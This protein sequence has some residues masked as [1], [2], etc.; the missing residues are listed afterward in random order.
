MTSKDIAI[1]PLLFRDIEEVV[2]IYAEV[3]NNIYIA[4]G[5]VAEGLATPT[6]FSIKA[7]KLFHQEM[8]RSIKNKV[9]K[10]Y[11]ARY[12]DA[13]VGFIS[14]E[15]KEAPAGHR[16]CWIRDLG[17]KKHFRRMGIAKQFMRE[18][19]AFGKRHKVRYFFLESGERNTGAHQFFNREGFSPLSTIFVKKVVN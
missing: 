18:A 4:Y 3:T 7:P 8:R 14:L 19:Y 17:V 2:H 1:G 15:I 16:E 10:V 5:E 11:V 13:T 9:R 12:E 6:S